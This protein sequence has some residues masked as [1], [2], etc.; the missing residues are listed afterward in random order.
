MYDDLQQENA[1]DIKIPDSTLTKVLTVKFLDAT[2][3]ENLT[4]ND[5]VTRK[6]YLSVLMSSGNHC[7][8]LAYVMAKLYYSLEYSHFGPSDLCF[9]GTGNIRTKTY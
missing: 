3:D 5:H 4:F 7:Q 8:L 9:T 1:I 2:P 6:K